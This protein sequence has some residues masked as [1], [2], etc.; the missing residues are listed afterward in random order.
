MCIFGKYGLQEVTWP[1]WSINNVVFILTI[2]E[3]SEK[4]KTKGLTGEVGWYRR[5][6]KKIMSTKCYKS[7]CKWFWN[8]LECI[9]FDLHDNVF[10]YF[11]WQ[12]N[13]LILKF[14]TVQ[15]IIN[16]KRKK[17]SQQYKYLTEEKTS[18]SPAEAERDKGEPKRAFNLLYK[19]PCFW[20]CVGS[21][22]SV[23]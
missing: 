23:W 9:L 17:N 1:K 4:L 10:H 20:L 14:Q 18:P 16:L 21:G 12:C 3:E 2:T 5:E 13:S 19:N 11:Q 7:S 6:E 8:L 15:P 22:C